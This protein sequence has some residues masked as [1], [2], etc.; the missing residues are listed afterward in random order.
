MGYICFLLISVGIVCLNLIEIIACF[1]KMVRGH[2]DIPKGKEK[3]ISTLTL[4]HIKKKI[5]SMSYSSR[6]KKQTNTAF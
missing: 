3:L 6:C 4:Y 1:N 2:L 5:N